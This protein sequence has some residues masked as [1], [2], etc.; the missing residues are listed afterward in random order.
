MNVLLIFDRSHMLVPKMASILKNAGHDIALVYPQKCLADDVETELAKLS[1]RK[2]VANH[3]GMIVASCIR[4]PGPAVE[5]MTAAEL[6]DWAQRLVIA[7]MSHSLLLNIAHG[8]TPDLLAMVMRTWPPFGRF[9]DP[10]EKRMLFVP[11]MT[12]GM[13][14]NEITNEH[15]QR[16]HERWKTYVTVVTPELERDRAPTGQWLMDDPEKV[17]EKLLWHLRLLP[18]DLK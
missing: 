14:R 10:K 17:C 7:P 8:F 16:V 5:L 11:Y 15:I 6:C 2:F 1:L 4:F 13:W 3:E 12:A 9:N 18:S